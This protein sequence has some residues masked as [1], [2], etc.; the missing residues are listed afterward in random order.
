V[1]IKSS[2]N[3]CNDGINFLKILVFSLT[4]YISKNKYFLINLKD[5]QEV[6][7]SSVAKKSLYLV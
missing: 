3:L 5:F 2:L 1:I 6:L 7:N 4:K